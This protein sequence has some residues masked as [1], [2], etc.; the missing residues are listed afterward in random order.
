M[1]KY[2]W[3]GQDGE[4][5]NH[6]DIVYQKNRDRIYNETQN[7]TITYDYWVCGGLEADDNMIPVETDNASRHNE[8]KID[9]SLIPVEATRQECAVWE[10]GAK[11]YDRNNWK[12]L[13][14][15]DTT[16]VVMASLLRHAFA[17]LDGEINDQETGLPHAAHIRCNAAMLL[18]YY[19]KS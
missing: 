8:G 19:K 2:K 13:W 6:G 5:F 9:L 18:E 7:K 17:I 16:N 4:F 3:I 15:D 14:G 10:L 11:K 1:Q 12:K